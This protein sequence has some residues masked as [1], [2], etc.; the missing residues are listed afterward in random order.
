ME[1]ETRSFNGG[2]F[3]EARAL[4]SRLC[5]DDKLAEFLTLEAYDHLEKTPIR[6]L[7]ITRETAR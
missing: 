6:T 4:F 5:F 7:E 1:E 2:R 3:R